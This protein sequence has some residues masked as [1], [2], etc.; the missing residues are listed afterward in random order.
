MGLGF[1]LPKF[2]AK[3]RIAIQRLKHQINKKNNVITNVTRREMIELLRS[4]KD[5]SARIRAESMMREQR[6]ITA[7]EV[8]Q[9]M[10][11]L[12]LTRGLHLEGSKECPEDLQEAC[13]SI[14]YAATRV[15][16]PELADMANQL[17]SKFGSQWAE[18]HKDNEALQVNRKLVALLD[19]KP[20]P[21]QSV[22]QLMKEVAKMYKYDWKPKKATGTDVDTMGSHNALGSVAKDEKETKEKGEEH[23][24][25]KG[26]LN[27]TVHAAKNL[28]EK[29]WLGSKKPFIKVYLSND[30]KNF[31]KTGV[32]N[33]PDPEWKSIHFPFH[34]AGEGYKLHVEVQ[35]ASS[36]RDEVVSTLVLD[37]DTVEPSSNL[38][39]YPLKPTIKSKKSQQTP[40][41]ALSFQFMSLVEGKAA[42]IPIVAGTAV[43]E[44]Q[45]IT[46]EI[47]TPNSSNVAPSVP[48]APITQVREDPP[49]AFNEKFD[50]L[51]SIPT[52]DGKND[53]LPCPPGG[54]LNPGAGRPASDNVDPLL[55]SLDDLP[56]AP[57]SSKGGGIDDLE[58]R[59]KQL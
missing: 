2:K 14:L 54:P 36:A 24:Y 11:E 18:K 21:Y 19:I 27:V 7:M 58:A 16:I 55:Q 53:E 43:P 41:I 35:N 45:L 34:V 28:Y 26:T 5:E 48:A 57:S 8:I 3:I 31:R 15:D 22:L 37:V 46:G 49:P 30:K 4:G 44:G 40:Q 9:M 12:L 6:L 52:F 10:C 33:G 42:S 20:P 38:V 23:D 51:P 17:G 25:T 56:S 1:S 29:S 32:A 59:F 13:S 50:D 39:W 47:I